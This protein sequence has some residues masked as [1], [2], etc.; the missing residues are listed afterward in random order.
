M[1]RIPGKRLR[2]GSGDSSV[3]D[4]MIEFDV[5]KTNLPAIGYRAGKRS[6]S[7]RNTDGLFFDLEPGDITTVINYG[8][9]TYSIPSDGQFLTYF[10][11]LQSDVVVTLPSV[12]V[13]RGKRYALA[14]DGPYNGLIIASSNGYN[15]EAITGRFNSITLMANIDTPEYPTDWCVIADNRNYEEFQHPS[16]SENINIHAGSAEI[17][18]ITNPT[19]SLSVILPQHVSQG[20]KFTI[21]VENAAGNVISLKSSSGDV[22]DIFDAN[23]WIT[24]IAK[25]QGP[26]VGSAWGV[27]DLYEETTFSTAFKF[28]GTGGGTSDA[29]NFKLSRRKNNVTI[30]SEKNLST[31][32]TG[33]NSSKMQSQT[34]LPARF[35]VQGASEF[36]APVVI[37][38]GAVPTANLG[39]LNMVYQG[40]MIVGKSASGGSNFPNATTYCG[41]GAN[42]LNYSTL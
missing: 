13:K 18:R 35:R 16:N 21:I 33:T 19:A 8:S 30:I 26:Q 17:H 6:L 27:F 1:E 42:H 31:A 34:F 32:S 40:L 10:T 11:N 39:V 9:P 4:T 14:V 41:F 22:I 15:F 12:D 36:Y 3:I 37:Y 5:G 24:V 20:K 2:I 25:Y 28:N 23:G 7:I 29:F 38:E